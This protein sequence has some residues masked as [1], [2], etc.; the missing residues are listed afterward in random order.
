[1]SAWAVDGFDTDMLDVKVLSKNAGKLP[2]DAMIAALGRA[3]VAEKVNALQMLAIHG[4]L[5]ELEVLSI[6][7]LT[8]DES[9]SVRGAAARALGEAQSADLA[10]DHLLRV[11]VDR[12]ATV[13]EDAAT[14]L[15][16]LGDAVLPALIKRLQIDPDVA[17]TRV[18]PHVAGFGRVAIEPL[19]ATLRHDDERVRANAIAGLILLGTPV[20]M[21]REDEIRAMV[22]DRS[23]RVR[24]LVREALGAIHRRLKPPHLA[25]RDDPAAGFTQQ[26][27][28]DADLKKAAE[29]TA[30]EDLHTWARDGRTAARLN[31]WRCLGM[32]GTLDDYSTSLGLVALKD[33]DNRVRCM[34]AAALT[35][36]PDARIGDVVLGLVQACVRGNREV[37]A[38]AQQALDAM[39]KKTLEPMMRMLDERDQETAQWLVQAVTRHGDK[40]VKLLLTA[41][42]DVRAVVRWNAVAALWRI[43]GKGLEK[44]WDQV[45]AMLDDPFDYAR[46]EAVL[47]LGAMP[48]GKVAKDHALMK[49]LKE[50]L[51]YDASLAVR[52]AADETLENIGPISD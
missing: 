3:S 42:D 38:A 34:A 15:A 29:A 49:R 21:E 20:L 1:M 7:V 52:L 44:S 40:A 32:R 9:A 26:P 33:Q 25:E 37:Q 12:D 41:M 51:E 6:G 22:Q 11:A 45:V 16:R 18:L 35:S 50:M 8:R 48:R 47:A 14:A 27:L 5:D 24:K 23:S 2:R 43:G 4:E 30:L 39:E 46:A 36:A 13:R 31:A 17:D 19:V 28:S 10:L